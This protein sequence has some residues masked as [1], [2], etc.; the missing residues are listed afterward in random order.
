[1]S[2]VNAIVLAAGSGKRMGSEIP[3]Q[4]LPLNGKPVMVYSLE[5][6]AKSSVDGI[7]L[8][9]APGDVEFCQKE[10]VEKYHITKV[11]S[12]VE[13]GAERYDSVYRGSLTSE[14][15]IVLVHD[16]A[17]AFV[18]QKVIE[19]AIEGA[20]HYDA[21]VVAVPSKD[22]VKIATPD[23]FVESTPRREL[24][25]DVQTPQAFSYSLLRGAYEKMMADS[26]QEGITDDAMVVERMTDVPV[27]LV[28][29]DYNNIKITTPEDLV[30]GEKILSNNS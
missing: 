13:G 2:R 9:V 30:L 1:M 25:W 15:D 10:I 19:E 27:R 12:I 11:V 22:T 28:Q 24:V 20:E 17:R 6:F 8:V 21:C 18:S 23:G 5:S 3:K 29:G 14:S 4:Y 26:A 7:I 16:S